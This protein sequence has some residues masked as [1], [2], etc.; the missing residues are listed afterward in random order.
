VATGLALAVTHPAAGNIGGGGFMMIRK[1]NGDTEIIDYRERAPLGASREMY[2]DKDG[3]VIK[4]A[5]T[6]GYRAVGVPGTVAGLSLALKHHGKL[7]WADVV[8]PARKL[9]AD[10]FEMNYHLTRSL[11]GNEKLL[12]QFPDSN[13]IFLKDGKFYDEGE[14]LVQPELAATLARLKTKGPREFYEGKTAQLIAADMKAHGGLI[15]EKDLKEYEPTVRK[16]IIGHYRGL[17]IVTMPPPS[18]G[19]AA[20]IEMLNILEHYNLSEMGAASSNTIHLLVESQRR[21]F[22]DRA[23]YMGDADFVK[24]PVEGLVSKKYAAELANTIDPDHATPSEKVKAGRPAGYESTETTHFTVIDSEGNVV[25]NTYTLNGGYGSGAT[26]AGTGILLNNEMDDFTSKPGVPNAYGLLQ[27][28]NNAIAPR[29]RPLSA[30]TP[31][32]VLKDGKVWFAIGSPG[33]PTIIN[34]V[35]QVIVN[36]VDFGMNIQ[37]AIDAPRFHHQWMP[38]R[39]QFE[40]MGINKDTRAALEKM[41]HS[42]AEK[43]GNMGDAEGIM[44]DAKTGMRLGA[45]DPRSGGAAVGY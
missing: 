21:A 22:A 44:I 10:G 43:P 39:I 40:P 1:S 9:A 38:D 41:G 34:T 37:Q 26:A 11:R 16:P 31:T 2:L 29:K 23:E 7:S 30:M 12:S 20:L 24:V 15:T 32:I 13:R 17:E 8:E 4:G 14:R 27:S 33:G 5:S 35:L 25:T 3:N 42:F 19:G 18:S 28:E 6:I 36:V 45:S